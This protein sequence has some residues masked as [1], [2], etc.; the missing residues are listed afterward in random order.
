MF[1][2]VYSILAFP[3]I[4]A[5]LQ[6]MGCG[7]K[8]GDP[9][10]DTAEAGK[11]NG[12]GKDD[13]ERKSHAAVHPLPPDAAVGKEVE[14]FSDDSQHKVTDKR[15]WQRLHNRCH[16]HIPRPAFYPLTSP[17]LKAKC[18]L[19][20]FFLHLSSLKL[21]SSSELSSELLKVA[22]SRGEL[23]GEWVAGPQPSSPSA[24]PGRRPDDDDGMEVLH[25]ADEGEPPVPST[26]SK[27]AQLPS[28]EEAAVGG[29]FG[30]AS[31]RQLSVKQRGPG[32]FRGAAGVRGRGPG[33]GAA[34]ARSAS[35][36]PS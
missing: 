26:S 19:I 29:S 34:I 20:F 11:T 23:G 8:V 21:V 17:V 14:P 12:E 3:A 22:K 10:E 13:P 31:G 32:S 35:S 15:T 30:L 28:V 36:K 4:A 6:R 2:Q 16:C 5:V 25:L 27:E 33:P 9:A 1:G 24:A 7:K 18:H